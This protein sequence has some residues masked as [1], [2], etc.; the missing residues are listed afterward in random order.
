L[1]DHP[2]Q[3]KGWL[4]FRRRKHGEWREHLSTL[5]FEFA[6]PPWRYFYGQDQPWDAI[7]ELKKEFGF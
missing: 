2:V 5:S 3:S 6:I 1:K 7:A 4:E